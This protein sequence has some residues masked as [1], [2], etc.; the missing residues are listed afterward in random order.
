DGSQ[1]R[2]FVYV[3]DVVRACLSAPSAP[4]SDPVNIGTGEMISVQ[5]LYGKLARLTGFDQPPVYAEAR[6]GEVHSIALD[7]ALAGER[8]GW[9]PEVGL[10]AG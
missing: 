10:D 1:R 4:S 3:G 9:S 7:P 2:D 5:A 6:A 8:L